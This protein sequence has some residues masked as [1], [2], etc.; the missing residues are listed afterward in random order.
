MLQVLF[1]GIRIQGSL[2]ASR[3]G[4]RALLEFAAHKKITPVVMTFPLTID[5]VET[6]MQT[7]RDGKMRYRGVLVKET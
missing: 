1:K 3:K 7:L 4:I 6:A 2:V 5:G